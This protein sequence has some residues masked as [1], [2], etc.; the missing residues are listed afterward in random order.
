MMVTTKAV[1]VM[2]NKLNENCKSKSLKYYSS[3]YDLKCISVST[4]MQ[5]GHVNRSNLILTDFTGTKIV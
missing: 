1:V 4:S 5:I 3:N 2:M